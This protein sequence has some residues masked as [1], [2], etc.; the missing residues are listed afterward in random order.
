MNYETLLG[1]PF[2]PGT[3]D[4]FRVV[5]DFYWIN[6][7]IKIRNYARPADWNEK[8]IDI[9]SNAYARE[10]FEKVVDWRLDTL[11]PGDILCMAVGSH[12]ANHQAIYIGG[13][14]IIHHKINSISCKETLRDFWRRSICYVLRHPSVQTSPDQKQ[15]INLTELLRDRNRLKT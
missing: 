7:G 3:T 1:K 14:E 12:V 10:G 5:I 11:Q 15:T 9:I 6:F 2:V 4:C 8:Q 13:N